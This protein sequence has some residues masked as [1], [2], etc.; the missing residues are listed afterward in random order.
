MPIASDITA[1][2]GHTPLVR[3]NRLPQLFS[4]Q[5]ELIAKLESF[6]PTA[7]VKDRI[8]GAMIKAAEQAGT[9]APGKTKLVEPT[10][11]NTGIA[12]AM[13]A[14]AKGYQLILSM[15]ATMSQERR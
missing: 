9:I 5:A 14:A 2:V 15:P 12:L 10:S 1:L 4:C 7:S 3:L 13:V 11:G 8:A 6:N